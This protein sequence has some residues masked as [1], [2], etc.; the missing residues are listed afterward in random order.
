MRLAVGGIHTECSTYSRVRT[1]AED[2]QT[3]RDD[4]IL[5]DEYFRFL[6]DY[7]SE[8]TPTFYA[9]AV[10][11]GPVERAAYEQFKA[12]F[13]GRLRQLGPL[14]GLYFAMHGAMYVDGM[15][16]A[17]GDWISAAREVVGPDC[18]ISAS[19][20]LHGNLSRQ[21]TDNLDML[22]AYRTAPHI[23]VEETMRRACDMLIRCLSESIRP[24]LVWVPIPVLMPGERS[25]TEDEPAKS[26][27]A[28]LPLIN[29][30]A[31]VLDA[32]LLVGY[33]WADEPRATASA[34]ITGTDQTVLEREALQLAREYWNARE[35]FNFGNVKVG[36]IAE[37]ITLAEQSTTA[38]VVLAE[39]GDN[40]TGGGVGDRAEVLNALLER[41]FTNALVAGIADRPATET[42]YRHEV[43]SKL[44]LKI[45]A[46]LDPQGS[47]PVEIEAEIVFLLP[48]DNRGDRQAVIKTRDITVVLTASRRPF[49]HIRDFTQLGL[50]IGNYKL[51]VVKSG[52]LSPELA[53]IANPNLMALSD[54]AINQ[55]IEGLP[56]NKFRPPTFPFVRL[57]H[58]QPSCYLS[59]R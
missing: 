54:G 41:N 46:S 9:R 53:P 49:H 42:C 58:W 56:P 50:I 4:E 19:Y 10:P 44:T 59:A 45:G 31:G 35:H 18:L 8:F 29:G 27:Y 28:Q 57:S 15:H 25:S 13:L 24:M 40:P 12:E 39:S 30:K 17:E 23:D 26:L 6:Q 2:F 3:L 47:Q 51:L 48:T 21:I 7:P 11:G 55:N 43:G 33:V 38:P 20:D 5:R 16:D 37:C 1:K 52:Y 32:S 36:S 22:S 14:D 34:V